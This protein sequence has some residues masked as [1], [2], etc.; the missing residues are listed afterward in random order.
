MKAMRETLPQQFPGT[1]FAFLPADI[2]TQILNFG[3]PAPIDVQ[4]IGSKMEANR[5]YAEKILPRIARVPGIAD[6]RIQQAF[7]A[8]TFNVDVDRTRAQIVGVSERDVATKSAGHSGRQ[9]PDRADVLAQSKERRFV[10]DR[11]PDA[12]ILGELALKP[13][14]YSGFAR[15]GQTDPRRRGHDQARSEQ[16]CRIA[17]CRSARHRHF[18]NQQWP[19]SRR[20]S[21]PISRRSWMTPPLRLPQVQ[22]WLFA[23]KSRR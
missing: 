2:V 18:R 20:R 13:R 8:P 23:D 16:R 11:R 3:L 19:G 22:L 5:A 6:P 7:N 12:A 4:I 9:H 1:T 17:L 15:F 14:E 10:P 21:R